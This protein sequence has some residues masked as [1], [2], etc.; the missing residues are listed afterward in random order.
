MPAAPRTFGQLLRTAAG[1]PLRLRTDSRLVELGDI[2]VAL[3]SATPG[4]PDRRADHLR[5]AARNGAAALVSSSLPDASSLPR[6]IAPILVDDAR[7]ALGKLAAAVL[8][9]DN[10]PFPLIGITGTNGKTTSAYLLE[11]L[12]RTRSKRVGV[13]G[14]VSYRWPGH[15]E[16]AP[17]TTPDCL[18]LHRALAAMAGSGSAAGSGSGVEVAVMEA[19]SHALEQK[20]VAGLRFSAALFTNLTQDH[21]DYHGDM[22]NYFQAKRLLFA[23]V[24]RAD[25]IMA[26]N[27]DDNYGRRLLEEFPQA[28]GY[29]FSAPA[30]ACRAWLG[31]ELQANT[32]AGLRLR[33]TY[34]EKNW[35]LESPLVGRHNASNLMG[36]MA[37]ALNCGFRPED[38]ACFHRFFGV[39]GRLERIPSPASMG[40]NT[41]IFVDYAHTPDALLRAQE[42]LREAGFAR[43]ITVFGCGGDRDRSKRPLMGEAV[44]GLSDIAVLTSDN[45]RTENPEAILNDIMPGLAQAREVHRESDR[46]KALSL[47]LGL[48]RPGDALLVAGKGHESCQIIGT[49]RYPFSDQAVL[50]ELLACS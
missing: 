28:A 22:E 16:E 43:L 36:V 47:A 18:T 49:A 4:K 26:V 7:D 45:P 44:A 2:F 6:G 11:H 10:L 30:P 31:G 15:E 21:L 17:L 37:L 48:L 40:E 3:P 50:K 34:G 32:P 19:A 25:K 20:R 41:G 8:H 46:R 33:L 12:Y 24:P 38:F 14:T 42:A 9:T 13:L 27:G 23:R 35:H 39:S 29:G 1:R 5:E